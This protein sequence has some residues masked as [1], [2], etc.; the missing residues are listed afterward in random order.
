MRSFIDKSGTPLSG[1]FLLFFIVILSTAIGAIVPSAIFEADASG[2]NDTK[3]NL[4]I[5]GPGPIRSLTENRICVFCHTPHNAYRLSGTALGSGL[6]APEEYTYLP[7]WNHEVTDQ[8]I[9]GLYWSSTLK[10]TLSQPTGPTKLC[11]SCH[12]GTVAIGAIVGGGNLGI[13]MKLRDYTPPAGSPN[14]NLGT[15]L[16]THHPVS[17]PYAASLPNPEL[18]SIETLPG[19]ITLEGDNEVHCTTC[20]NPHDNTYGNFLVMDNSSS[21]LCV[22]CHLL[23]GWNVAAHNQ[24]EDCHTPH[25]AVQPFGWPTGWLLNFSTDEGCLACHSEPIVHIAAAASPSSIQAASRISLTAARASQAVNIKRQSDKPSGHRMTPNARI[26]SQKEQLDTRRSWRK[27]VTCMGCHNPHSV[28]RRKASAP[29]ASGM[30]DGV[31]GVDR[32]GIEVDSVTYEYEVCFKCHGDY[33]NDYPFVPRV[34]VSN[35]RL[36]MDR[37]NPSYHPVVEHARNPVIPSIPSSLEPS[38]SGGSMIYCTDC[39]RDDEGGARGPHGSSI[40]PI[41]G[42]RYETTDGPTESYQRYALCY[43]CHN[44]DSILRDDSFKKNFLGK[45]GHSGHLADGAPCSA[46]HDP[47]GIKDDGMSGSH[48]HLINFDTRIV[49]PAP[50][51]QFP[52]FQDL[53]AFSGSCTLVCHGRTHVNEAYPQGGGISSQHRST[54]WPAQKSIRN[55]R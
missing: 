2:I 4:S 53:G 34:I 41:L 16:S 18:A 15:D 42:E 19:Q 36:A 47:H 27:E 5:S 9:T 45:G 40:L 29:Y 52:F 51:N 30:L 55:F 22:A 6:A 17:F 25:F 20:H 11:L 12:D 39:H 14:T 49:S 21:Q 23:T 3:H 44:R 28:N 37:N 13:Q 46:C 54:L 43:R 26:M 7:L 1:S 50:G 35:I 48:T 10:A 24:C 31:S 8:P 32:D 33:S 38:L